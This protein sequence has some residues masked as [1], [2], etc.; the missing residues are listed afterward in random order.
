MV[1]R[2]IRVIVDPSGARTGLNQVERSAQR[3]TASIGNLRGVL[4][5]A[6]A[7]LGI[8][9][10]GEY[11]DQWTTI[12][13]RLKLVTD[14]ERELIVVRR[15]LQGLAQET[16]SGLNE[17]VELFSRV[18]RATEE[19]GTSQQDVLDLTRSV[20][21][22]IQIS[23]ATA[24]EASAGVIQFAQGLASGAL[25]GD[26]LRSVLEQ[27]PRLARALADGLGVGI[28][29]LREL[30]SEGELTAEKVIEALR[31][32]APEIQAEFDQITPSIESAFTVL[33]N[34]VL[35]LIG[36]LD[37]ALGVS[38]A[39][40]NGIIDLSGFITDASDDV[41]LFAIAVQETLGKAIASIDAFVSSADEKFR[42][43]QNS[44]VGIIA[45]VIGDEDVA[46]VAAQTR[47]RLEREL[48]QAESE[49]EDRLRQLQARIEARADRTRAD[50]RA[51]RSESPEDRELLNLKGEIAAATRDQT[52]AEKE[53]Q[54]ALERTQKSAE[55]LLDRLTDQSNELRLTRELG[56][57]AAAALREIEIAQLAAAGASRETVDALRAVS[58]EIERQEALTVAADRTKE[59]SEYIS[60]L[61]Q[62]LSLLKL[63]N[64]QREIQRALIELGADATE[65]QKAQVTAIIQEMQE[66]KSASEDAFNFT[67]AIAE[68]TAE[69]IR[70]VFKEAL[71]GDFDDIQAEFANFLSRLGQELLT[72][73]L[74][75]QLANLFTGLAGPGGGNSFFG[76][77]GQAFGGVG[78]QFGG[79]VDAGQPFIGAEGGGRRPEV[80][81]PRQAGRIEPVAN[82]SGQAPT[83]VIVNEQDPE[84]LLAVNRTRKGVIEQ[85]NF[86]T[87]DQRK[88]N[89]ALGRR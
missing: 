51:T 11:A 66:L 78:R 42:L 79:F 75:Q 81:I 28:G 83:I 80:F 39:F 20:N 52:D 15:E 8:R 65:E 67:K 71:T 46:A 54:K 68:Q 53:Y 5:G 74:Q 89:R 84:G 50:F 86:V 41:V 76:F 27:T 35:G 58:V 38:E 62:E 44:L 48:N 73:L 22:A 87:A 37:D 55:G 69:G 24:Q 12:N 33:D 88:I 56:D 36:D 70:G 26:E 14:S 49:A 18:A 60:E 31:K 43:F 47:I 59:R 23:G 3:T 10:L 16:R 34:A 77:L 6:I 72:S 61:N 63:T 19:L 85:R 1:D 21:Q 4:A 13:N 7:A 32:T 2:V 82:L 57:G 40:A 25:R 17:T 29:E 45:T 9:Q 30:G 64:E